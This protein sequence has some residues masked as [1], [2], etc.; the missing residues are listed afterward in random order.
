MRILAI[1][2]TILVVLAALFPFDHYAWFQKPRDMANVRAQ[3]HLPAD[4]TFVHFDSD[5]KSFRPEGL[6]SE[7]TVE[8]DE[9]A[10]AAYLAAL[11]DPGVWKPVP[12]VSYSPEIGK[13]YSAGA[14]AWRDL[15]IS[16]ALQARLDRWRVALPGEARG[17][18]GKVYC[19]VL[20]MRAAGRFEHNPS[21]IRYETVGRACEELAETDWPVVVVLA[22]LDTRTRRIF[23]ALKFSG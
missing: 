12:L 7:A 3:L 9:A 11:G 8:L 21:A 6:R 14:L 22:V 16:P 13:E 4:A 20:D 10:F 18:S 19:S 23:A 2:L 1:V 17:A 15:P 5:P